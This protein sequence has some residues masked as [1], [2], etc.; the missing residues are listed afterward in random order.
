MDVVFCAF[1]RTLLI[2]GQKAESYNEYVE[3]T[4]IYEFL[5]GMFDVEIIS[6]GDCMKF[7]ETDIFSYE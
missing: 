3:R 6:Y 1:F 5:S 7:V 2:D 4:T